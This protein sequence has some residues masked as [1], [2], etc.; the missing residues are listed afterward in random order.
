MFRNVRGT[1][2]VFGAVSRYIRVEKVRLRLELADRRP[3]GGLEEDQMG[4]RDVV[5]RKT[6]LYQV[7]TYIKNLIKLLH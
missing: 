6:R 5:E 4:F 3:R 2:C 1:A 7:Q